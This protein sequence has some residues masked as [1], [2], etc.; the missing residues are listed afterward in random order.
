MEVLLILQ[1][2]MALY[3][4][5]FIMIISVLE[6]STFTT[7]VASQGEQF[8]YMALFVNALFL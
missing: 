2:D 8:A 6:I 4:Y 5:Q 3:G 1:Q 7:H